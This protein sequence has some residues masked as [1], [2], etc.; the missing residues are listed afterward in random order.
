VALTFEQLRTA[1][2]RGCAQANAEAEGRAPEV[3]QAIDRLV[4]ASLASTYAEI[5]QLLLD[6]PGVMTYPVDPLG[7]TNPTK[8][9]PQPERT[10][11]VAKRPDSRPAARHR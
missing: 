6:N 3:V 8:T 5:K 9:F 11:H 7:H 4:K 2:V 10:D 1:G